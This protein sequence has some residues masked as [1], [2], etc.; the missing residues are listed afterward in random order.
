MPHDDEAANRRV[1]FTFT[2]RT[3]SG[4]TAGFMVVSLPARDHGLMESLAA[5]PHQ[6]GRIQRSLVQRTNQTMKQILIGL[7]FTSAIVA[8]VATGTGVAQAASSPSVVG[9]K[10]SDAQSALSGAGF[11]IVV[12]NT[13]GDQTARPDCVV[14]HQQDRTVPPPQNTSASPSKQTLL[15]LNCDAQVASA[16]SPGNS[17][18]SPVGRAAAAAAAASA[19]AKTPA[20]A[21]PS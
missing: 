1:M 16:K 19:A 3:P 4:I 11:T 9:Q 10:Y 18:A 14:T 15:A 17:L 6:A 8:T 13:V 2:Q 21:P 12:S 5:P 20:P 7:A